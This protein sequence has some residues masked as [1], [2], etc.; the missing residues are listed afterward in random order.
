MTI[1]AVFLDVDD[2]LVDYQF[3]ART[4]FQRAVGPGG[5]YALFSGLDHYDRF[6]RGELEFQIARDQRMV[7]Y[8]VA[9]GRTADAA[10]AAAIE[11]IRFEGLEQYY[12]LFDDV[13]PLFGLL[14]SRGVS[15][16]LIT[17]NESAHQRAKLAKVGLDSIVDAIVISDEVGVA[18]PEARIFAQACDLLGVAAGEALHIG[19]N[20]EA[21]A[22]GA[23]QAGL[24]AVWLDRL[25]RHDG[26]PLAY[27]VIS[28]LHEVSE[29]LA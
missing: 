10:D 16:G 29:L 23:H 14:R 19:D 3:A 4:A 24:Q 8:L 5:D 25:G 22:D 15:I 28:D 13:G 18:K 6:L 2:T 1:R 12:R 27:R 26:T 7:D 20:R 9:V 11:A 17:N 21:D